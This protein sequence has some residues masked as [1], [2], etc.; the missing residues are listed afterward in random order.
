MHLPA[1][2]SAA[3]TGAGS[4]ARSP[5]GSTSP[6]TSSRCGPHDE[7]DPWSRPEPSAAVR[8]RVTAARARQAER[9]AGRELAAQR[10]GA[11]A[12]AARGSGRCRRRRRRLVDDRLYAGKL[13]RRGATRVHRLAWT[14]ADLAGRRRARPSPR[15]TRRCGC[16][17]ASRCCPRRSGGR[18]RD[19]RPA[20][21]GGAEP[22]RPSPA[23]SRVARPLVAELGAGRGSASEHRWRTRGRARATTGRRRR[24]PAGR[25]S[26]R[27][28]DLEQAERLGIRFVVPGD[29]EWPTQ[30]DDLAH[31]RA[32][33]GARR[34]RRSGSG[35]AVRC[36]STSSPTRS[37]SSGRARPRP[38]ARTSPASSA[39]GLARAGR[40]CVSGAAFGIDQAAHRGALAA[41]G[42]S[43][44]VLACGVDRA[45]PAAHRGLLDHLA[46]TGA[47]V[48]RAAAGLRADCGCGSWPATGSSPRSP[49]A[50]S[51]VEAA[52][53]SGALNTAELG[54]RACPAR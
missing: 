32:G 18:P 27:R 14:V 12:R 40:P 45:Y 11:R 47:V 26:T 37:R 13:S 15:P 7:R 19:R 9:Y 53:R 16:A 33:P 39:A 29:D 41:D 25:P 4:A 30:L 35:S 48:S 24:R 49:A 28:R 20:G 52:V 46:A 2:R 36:A 38:T 10:P 42:P 6:A 1:R 51:L 31:C 54:D 23:T 3:T 44:A 8:A 21:P 43:V 5:T 50:R 34:C 17:P 22:A